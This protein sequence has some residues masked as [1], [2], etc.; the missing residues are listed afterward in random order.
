[1]CNATA[2][3]GFKLT[4]LAYCDTQ[5]ATAMHAC[6]TSTLALGHGLHTLQYIYHTVLNC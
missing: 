6:A 1:M 2:S 4:V 3:N 5:L